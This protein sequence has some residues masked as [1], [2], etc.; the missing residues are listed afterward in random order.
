[1]L[2]I[3]NMKLARFASN[4]IRGFGGGVILEIVS[5]VGKYFWAGPYDDPFWNLLTSWWINPQRT[6]QAT[7]YPTSATNVVVLSGS[8]I[9]Y[10]NLD[11]PTWVQPLSID[12]GTT[13]IT[14]YSNE[15]RSVTCSVTATSPGIMLFTGSA[16]YGF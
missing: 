11:L 6:A 9:P 12:T 5:T 8:G 15:S 2:D 4:S 16:Y 14:F 7:Q 10:V 1:M 13:G 3:I